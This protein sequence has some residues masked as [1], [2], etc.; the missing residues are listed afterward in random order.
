MAEW[1]PLIA[2][3]LPL[4]EGIELRWEQTPEAE[5]RLEEFNRPYGPPAAP[6]C[7][8]ENREIPGSHGAVPV[9][10]YSPLDDDTNAANRVALVWMHGGAFMFGDLDMPESDHVARGLVLRTG[11]VVVAVDYRLAVDGV[12]FPVPHDDCLAAYQW[13]VAHASELGIDAERVAIG[14]TSAGGNLAASVSLH[15]RDLGTPPWQAFLCY[16][17]CHAAMPRGTDAAEAAIAQ[18][19]PA[20]QFPPAIMSELNANYL[21][22]TPDEVPPHAF[23]GESDDLSGYPRTWI[24]NDEFDSLRPSG[25]AFAVALRQ[26]GVDVEVTLAPGVPHGHL[27]M[28]GHPVAQLSLDRMAD[29]L[30]GR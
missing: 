4:L 7:R 16:P 3:R 24:E 26:A 13:T 20:L 1:D 22:G 17:V 9:R 27:N 30:R 5:R 29:R 2:E 23:P 25:E 8:V 11:C 19:P 10:V 15:L 18:T 14:G 6:E 21:G 12:H 28:V